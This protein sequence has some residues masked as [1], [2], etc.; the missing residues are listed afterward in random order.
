MVRMVHESFKTCWLLRLRVMPLL[1]VV[2]TQVF[3]GMSFSADHKRVLDV[4]TIG[5]SKDLYKSF[6][7]PYNDPENIYG[8][9]KTFQEWNKYLEKDSISQNR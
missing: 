6:T 8:R 5:D 7:T 2:S 3:I 9:F 4:T 1:E